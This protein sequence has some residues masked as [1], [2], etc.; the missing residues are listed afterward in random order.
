LVSRGLSL[1]TF[2]S[3]CETAPMAT[4]NRPNPIV[5]PISRLRWKKFE[6]L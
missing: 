4:P 6:Q 3:D 2:A 5:Q 1:M